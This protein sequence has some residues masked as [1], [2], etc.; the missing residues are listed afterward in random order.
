MEI[1]GEFIDKLKSL[2]KKEIA[3]VVFLHGDLGA[4]KTTFT[5][6]LCEYLG[7]DLD[8]TSPTFTILK[9]YPFPFGEFKNL[10]HID[11]YRL[12][13]YEELL[14]IKFEDYLN[15]KDNL[16]F[17]EWPEMVEGENVRPDLVL[18]FEHIDGGE[19]RKIVLE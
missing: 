17:I 6:R 11:A 19:D 2:G 13:S 10:I 9:K 12:N 8:I 14:K 3:T 15:D 5:K 1:Y 18:R 16:I 4:G 7:F